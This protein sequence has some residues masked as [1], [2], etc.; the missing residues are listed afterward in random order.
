MEGMVQDWTK[1]ETEILEGHTRP[2]DTTPRT[3]WDSAVRDG[4]IGAL[5]TTVRTLFEDRSKP[6]HPFR[7][8]YNPAITNAILA[9]HSCSTQ[10][11]IHLHS[12]HED[13]SEWHPVGPPVLEFYLH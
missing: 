10:Q 1:F 9:Y 2:P 7:N 4:D 12:P 11:S 13:P 5:A 6:D 8:S 3:T